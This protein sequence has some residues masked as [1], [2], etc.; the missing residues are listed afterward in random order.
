MPAWSPDD[1]E[2]VFTPAATT[3]RALWAV[4][5]ATKAER[6]IAGVAKARSLPPRY[7]PGGQ[8]VY[9]SSDGNDSQLNLDGKVHHQET[10]WSFPS[11]PAGFPKNEFFY[12]ADG[13]IKRRTLGGARQGSFP[14]RPSWK[15]TPRPQHLCPQEARFRQPDAAPGA[16]H[17]AADPV[18]GRQDR[19]PLSRWA[20]SGWCR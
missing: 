17:R 16:G 11:V 5:V 1:K 20:I 6:K 7:G 2:I 9:E 3:T 19:S 4:N 18:A 10:K 15:I 12:T 13:K 8:L 14:S